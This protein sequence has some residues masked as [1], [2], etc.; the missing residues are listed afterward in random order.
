MDTER[1]NIAVVLAGGSGRRLGC[2]L[3]KQFIEVNGRA[4]IEYSIDAFE[5]CNGI[6][7]IA[8]VV[9]K[10]FVSEMNRIVARNSWTKLKKILDGGVER[11]DSS[12]SAIKAYEGVPCNLIFHD[13]VRPLVSQ[14]IIADVV[15]A[16]KNYNAVAVSVQPTD[17][18]VEVDVSG[19]FIGSIP[20]RSMLR[21][22]QTP[23]AFCYETI[24]K[25]YKLAK[26]DSEFVATDDC[27]VVSRYL[28]D[29]TIFIVDGDD[30]NI[31]VTY[32][33]D[34]RLLENLILE[35]GY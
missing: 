3:P 27:G 6:D 24:A 17:T 10:D 22:Q 33:K 12:L 9:N 2:D 5:K 30:S 34:L 8:V 26:E 1:Q 7:E 21:C 32:R 19:R 11:S 28:P 20:N 18:I 15:A 31:K 25:A 4:I 16:L 14:R 13:A 29:E 35:K 23:Q